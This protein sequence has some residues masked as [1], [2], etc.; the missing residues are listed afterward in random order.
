[1]KYCEAEHRRLLNRLRRENLYTARGHAL[2]YAMARDR[3]PPGDHYLGAA[4][5]VRHG[6][7]GQAAG[8]AQGHPG[9]QVSKNTECINPGAGSKYYLFWKNEI[10]LFI[11]QVPSG[12]AT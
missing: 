9:V 11:W 10:I 4:A 6:A 5:G 7:G 1:M 2:P 8:H 12:C 3:P